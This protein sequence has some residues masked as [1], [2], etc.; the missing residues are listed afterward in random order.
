M[1]FTNKVCLV[2]GAG[3]GIG[4]AAA[5][6]F[7]AE[8]GKVM[9]ID[10]DDKG[11]NETVHLIRAQNGEAIFSHCDVGLEQE[12]L[13]STRL[14]VDTW[15]KIDVLVNNAAMMTFKKIVDLSAAEWD[16]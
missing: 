5:L 11:G 16:Q 8:G 6:R 13:A 7:A 1:R 15:G 10:R 12:I 4:R 14:A 3:S 9:V 2:T